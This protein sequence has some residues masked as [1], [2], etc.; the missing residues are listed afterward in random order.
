MMVSFSMDATDPT[1]A[2]VS[3]VYIF[4]VEAINMDSLSQIDIEGFGIKL[5]PASDTLSL[6]ATVIRDL[7]FQEI[8]DTMKAIT[9]KPVRVGNRMIERKNLKVNPDN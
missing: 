9:K 3:E 1:G 5:I 2:N 8:N 4:P 6:E 7:S